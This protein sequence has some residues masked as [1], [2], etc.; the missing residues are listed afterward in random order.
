MA[1]SKEERAR[2]QQE[3][4]WMK[5]AGKVY[6]TK[7]RQEREIDSRRFRNGQLVNLGGG[8]TGI[9]IRD[10]NKFVRVKITSGEQHYSECF[11]REEIR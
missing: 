10:Y 2:R 9:V 7:L 4:Y 8:R 3:R 6:Q 11:Y 1:M 5:S